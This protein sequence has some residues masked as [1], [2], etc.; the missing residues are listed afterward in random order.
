MAVMFDSG[1]GP[2]WWCVLVSMWWWILLVEV[3]VGFMGF[4]HSGRGG[5]FSR[6]CWWWVL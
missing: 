5:F 2:V 3:V 6:W 4:V 1:F